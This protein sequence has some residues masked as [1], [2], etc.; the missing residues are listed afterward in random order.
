MNDWIHE[1]TTWKVFKHSCGA[2]VPILP[3][4][5]EAG[6]DIINPVQI[7][8]KDM[9]SG[10]LKRSLEAILPFGE[11]ESILRRCCLSVLG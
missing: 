1:H 3:G 9:D 7:N 5:I 8:A 10:M 6:F 4:L 2:I 11:V